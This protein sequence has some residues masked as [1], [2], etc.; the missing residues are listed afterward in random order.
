[1]PT[2]SAP[3]KPSFPSAPREQKRPRDVESLFGE[4]PRSRQAAG[5]LWSHQADQ[6]RTYNERHVSAPDV[7]LELPTGSGKTLVGLLV[8]EWRRQALDERIV[9]ACPTK[10]LAHQ[11]AL[12]AV[13]QGVPVRELTGRSKAWSG[14]DVSD[15]VQG[16]ALAVTTYSHIFNSNSRFADAD[17]VIFDD[18]HAAEGYVAEAW[19]VSVPKSDKAF[20]L[21]ID[22]LRPSLDDH[23][24]TR[25]TERGADPAN[26]SEV[27]LIPVSTVARHLTDLGSVLA[28]SLQGDAA[29]RYG[30]VR[31]SLLSCLFYVSRQGWYIRPMVPPTFQHQAFT[32]P[33]QRL[34]LSA[35]LGD[36]GELERAFG[37]SPIARVP[38]PPAWE[39]T[40]SGRRFFVFPEVASFDVLDDK[41]LDIETAEQEQEPK[42]DALL[43][44]LAAIDPKRLLLTPDADGA[45]ELADFI[46]TPPSGRINASDSD[47]VETFKA[48]KAATLLAPSRYDG[49]DLAGDSCR[50]TVLSGLPKASHLQDQFFESKLRAGDVLAER[51]RTRV[52]QGAGRCTRGPQDWAVIVVHGQ[53]LLRY[54]SNRNNTSAMPVE[55]QAEIEFGLRASRSSFSNVLALAQSALAQDQDWRENG[56]PALA[57]ARQR[58]ERQ[59][60]ALAAELSSSAGREIKAWQAAW[61]GDWE[62]AANAAVEVVEGLASPSA[63]PYRALWSYLASAWFA[64]S[65][66][67][68][69]EAGSR[70]AADLLKTAHKAAGGSTWLREIEP[71]PSGYAVREKSDEDAIE[72]VIRRLNG[73]LKSAVTFAGRAK[74]MLVDLARTDAGPYELA[75]VELGYL[76]G[77]D[78]FKPKG[79][80]RTDA[81]W[82][83]DELWIT[84]EAKSEQTTEMLSMDYVRKANTHLASVAADKSIDEAPAGSVTVIAATSELV[85]P[86]AVPIS[87]DN[88]H[89]VSVD[90]I[91]S[92][93]HETNR[94]I[95]QVRTT[96]A[97]LSIED[98]RETV[99]K[100]MWDY[101]ILPTQV[102]ELLTR[103]PI[104]GS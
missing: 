68:G 79:Q 21:L 14:R 11:V 13:D 48:S 77:A 88:L 19:A 75:L 35:T 59:P 76:L 69:N 41:D 29:Y 54:F 3:R 38:V 89:L 47:G 103:D 12:A 97:G 101:R 42:S 84:V 4:L 33:G 34:Y 16:S 64:L 74:T 91:L 62:G 99:G 72:N 90:V 22:V 9:Y 71:L 53:E 102:R 86:D 52:V 67:Y 26:R 10:Q 46:R 28:S 85:D 78:S 27:H 49:M 5:A 94:A 83:W 25:M 58:A 30:M 98:A 92:L 7:A 44:L 15:Y 55:M 2:P 39:K 95:S 43:P 51:I 23:L 80:G 40:G 1:M 60:P 82:L 45:A 57:D 61:I 6:L 37:R 93:A 18:A 70:R 100:L 104:K 87:N 24:L 20:T 8:G 31:E 50:L 65:A 66:Q 17:A 56:E 81:A 73:P 96:I 32:G 36:A 63:R